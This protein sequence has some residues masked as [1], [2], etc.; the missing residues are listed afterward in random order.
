[1]EN[2]PSKNDPLETANVTLAVA[3]QV[4]LLS[5]GHQ[6]GNVVEQ[7]AGTTRGLLIPVE[8]ETRKQ[9]MQCPKEGHDCRNQEHA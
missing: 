3:L 6:S 8:S 7:S 4:T 2:E 1:M 5:L 9:S